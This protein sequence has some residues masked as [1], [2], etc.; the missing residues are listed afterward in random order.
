MATL[1]EIQNLYRLDDK[2]N[3]IIGNL[4]IEDYTRGITPVENPIVIILGG[5]PGA[6]KSELITQA[7]SM[8]GK[9]AVICNADDYR[10]YHP[11][12]DEIKQKH[13]AYYPEITVTY[14]QPWNNRLK[15]HCEANRFNYILETTF[16]SGD[17]M[18]NTIR[19]LKEKGYTV[20]VMVLAVNKRLSFLGTR[21]RYEGM[22]ANDG[23]GRLVVQAVH[24]QKYELVAS[25][26]EAVQ[27]AHLY[28]KLFIYGRAG[29]QKV[30]GMRNGLVLLSENSINAVQDYFAEREKEW[31]DNDLRFFN[32]DVLHLIRLMVDRQAPYADIK[33][34]LDIFQVGL[35][36]K[37]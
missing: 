15:A 22:K 32:D 2:Q 11:K 34:V 37:S 8:I 9:N 5:Q 21:L 27:N 17:V 30:R 26:L 18:N 20:Y 36:D 6:G 31:S 24:D 7:Q 25:T 4:I 13:E 19:A 10:D 29:R 23:Y 16:S 14:S 1:E 35:G 28:D 33:Y 3:K 12:S